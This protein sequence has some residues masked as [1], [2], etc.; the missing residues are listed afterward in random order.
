MVEHRAWDGN[1]GDGTGPKQPCHFPPGPTHDHRIGI[2][3][4]KL[5][6]SLLVSPCKAFPTRVPIRHDAHSECVL[7]RSGA[8][9]SKHR[10]VGGHLIYR[11]AAVSVRAAMAVRAA[12]L[13]LEASKAPPSNELSSSTAHC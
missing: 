1:A 4:A 12:A 8:G 5:V 10:H 9:A 6:S 2:F 11:V 3:L 7:G 13:R